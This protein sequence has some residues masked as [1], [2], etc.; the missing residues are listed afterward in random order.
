MSLAPGTA[1]AQTTPPF[2]TGTH[3]E[4][5]TNFTQVVLTFNE[6][7]SFGSGFRVTVD[8]V[9][10]RLRGISPPGYSVKLRVDEIPPGAVVI[11]S[12]DP[13]S[14]PSWR[15]RGSISGL[16]AESFRWN[17]STNMEIPTVAEVYGA[18]KL[19]FSGSV[20]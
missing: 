10:R 8:G 4:P 17:V 16:F 6:I 7:V 13:P 14:N 12:Y 15:L 9:A 5:L 3:L 2:V 18:L 11:V 1:A 19:Y 20:T